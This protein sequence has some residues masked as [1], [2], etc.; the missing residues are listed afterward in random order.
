MFTCGRSPLNG[1]SNLER[2]IIDYSSS[3]GAINGPAINSLWVSIGFEL[4]FYGFEVVLT[5]YELNNALKEAHNKLKINVPQKY[6]DVELSI[7]NDGPY[8]END[9]CL[10]FTVTFKT[11]EKKDIN[12]CYKDALLIVKDYIQTQ[13][14]KIENDDTLYNIDGKLVI[15][16]YGA[17]TQIT[18]TP[19]CTLGV[20]YNNIKKLI[21]QMGFQ[22]EKEAADLVIIYDVERELK[23][24]ITKM[25]I[26]IDQE[27]ENWIFLVSYYYIYTRKSVDCKLLKLCM[28]FFLR[29]GLIS[30]MPPQ[31]NEFMSTLKITKNPLSLN[32]YLFY[33]YFL[34][35][36]RHDYDK[37]ILQYNSAQKLILVPH[38]SN[39]NIQKDPSGKILY[40]EYRR[41]A[42]E[43]EL[44][45][46]SSASI[47][48]IDFYNCKEIL[49]MSLVERDLHN[50]GISD[51]NSVLANIGVLQAITN[52]ENVLNQLNQLNIIYNIEDPNYLLYVSYLFNMIVTPFQS[53]MFVSSTSSASSSSSVASSL[54]QSFDTSS[55][56]A[57]LL[58]GSQSKLADAISQANMLANEKKATQ[59]AEYLLHL[60]FV[61]GKCV[62]KLRNAVR[63][64][65]MKEHDQSLLAYVLENIYGAL[66]SFE[67]AK[68]QL[69]LSL[70]P[71]PPLPP[72]QPVLSQGLTLH[73]PQPVSQRLTLDLSQPVLSQG[74]TL[75]LSQPVLSQ[76]FTSPSTSS[77]SAF[78]RV[79]RHKIEPATAASAATTS[80][81]TTS[82]KSKPGGYYSRLWFHHCY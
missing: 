7:G 76:V 3:G 28:P 81:A 44:R 22:T 6:N 46:I 35:H 63:K 21:I 9:Y 8:D 78:E 30:I 52:A 32:D 36:D 18:N 59:T 17:D 77:Q 61:F 33:L 4:E 27:I 54:K 24:I 13:F 65:H 69:K 37:C 5:D 20:E 55:F 41:L 82:D 49:D 57:R 79:K 75:D 12:D 47:K 42:S 1:N 2:K 38:E 70:S 62:E 10:E 73:R 14:F 66:Q 68:L 16:Q 50:F 80:A 72:S 48:I 51:Y 45:I 11:K 71:L 29:H 15:V 67:A 25:H 26:V 64:S 43:P 19:H 74:L 53:Q 56:N 31:L 60:I 58:E 40:I 34:Y 39:F 23:E